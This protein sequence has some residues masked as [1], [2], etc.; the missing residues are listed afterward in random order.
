MLSYWA[1]SPRS[2]APWA[3]R[4]PMV[5]SMSSTA[6]MTRCRPSVLGGGFSGSP[7]TATGVWYFVRPPARAEEGSGR[8]GG[9][10]LAKR[11]QRCAPGD[12]LVQEGL[13]RGPA[14]F[15]GLEHAEVLELG[16]ERQRDLLA[17]VGHLQFAGDQPQVLGGPGAAD[18][19][20]GDESDG[21][22]VPLGVEVVDGVLQHAGG[23]VVVLGGDDDEPVKGGNLL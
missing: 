20:V 1:T 17:D 16:D 23:A 22:V 9:C 21:L 4:R 2:S 7:P 10:R 5:S 19:A 11:R 14:V 15:A 3:R 8:H 13:E 12:D 6:N 18:R